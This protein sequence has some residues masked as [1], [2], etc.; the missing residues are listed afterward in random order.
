MKTK[1][2]LE[3]S[4]MG[5]MV[6]TKAGIATESTAL[7][8]FREYSEQLELDYPVMLFGRKVTYCRKCNYKKWERV[9]DSF[10]RTLLGFFYSLFLLDS[11]YSV[12]IQEGNYSLWVYYWHLQDQVFGNLKQLGVIS[13]SLQEEGQNIKATFWSFPSQLHADLMTDSMLRV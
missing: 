5:T 2:E 9:A 12:H 1:Q 13:I 8:A 7:C 6:T 3:T 4:V 11:D 10:I